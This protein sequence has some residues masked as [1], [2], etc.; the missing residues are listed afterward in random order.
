M[1]LNKAIIIGNVTRDP[2]LKA[3]PSGAKVCS[4]SLAT[5]RVWKDQ[6]GAKKE[7]SDFHNIVAF[8]R[9]AETIGQYVKKGSVLLVEGRIQTRSW[10][11]QDGKKNYR[12]E[13][14]MESFQFGPRQGG[15]T[16]TGPANNPGGRMV[17]DNAPANS[18]NESKDMETIEYPNDDINAEDIPF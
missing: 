14:V 15:S 7:Q 3:L 8:G 1:Y 16:G 6:A 18:H 2:E 13:I 5:N 10:D 17:D 4:F 11:G 12:T 9:Q